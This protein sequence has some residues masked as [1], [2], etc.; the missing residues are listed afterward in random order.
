VLDWGLIR[1]LSGSVDW[2]EAVALTPETALVAGGSRDFAV[3][4]WRLR[5]AIHLHTLIGHS[6]GVSAI[7]F[8]PDSRF[9]AIGSTDETVILWAI[10]P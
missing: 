10:E 2:V 9:L 8:S 1:T 3:Y 4:L 7:A 5:D 6:E